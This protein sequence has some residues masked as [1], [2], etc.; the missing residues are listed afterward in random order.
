MAQPSA[1]TGDTLERGKGEVGR[2]EPL[3]PALLPGW[4]AVPHAILRARGEEGYV[5]LLALHPQKGVA[6]LAFLEKDEVADADAAREAFADMLREADFAQLFPGS[7]PIVAL[8]LSAPADN[9][10]REL[11]RAFAAEPVP[12][13][14]TGWVE[15]LEGRLAPAAKPPLEP[16]LRLAAPIRDDATPPPSI[17]ALL[18]A[19]ARADD[20]EVGE[21]AGIEAPDPAPPAPSAVGPLR[22]TDWGISLGFASAI[23]LALLTVLA[24]FSRTGRLF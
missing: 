4:R 3:P 15:W 13:V 5:D 11:E 22:W 10:D 16:P 9:L 21:P 7:L 23:V 17:G 12:T 20:E 14:P 18:V 24:L 1:N 2:S 19:P 6:L 8:V